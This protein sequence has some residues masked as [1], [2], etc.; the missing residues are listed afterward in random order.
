MKLKY[1]DEYDLMR[2]AIEHGWEDP[3]KTEHLSVT[4]DRAKQYL[5][6]AGLE[7]ERVEIAL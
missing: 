5:M 2:I 4:G 6:N 1:E 7:L 3:G